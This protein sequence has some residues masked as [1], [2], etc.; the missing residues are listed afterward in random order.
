MGLFKK[1]P[2]VHSITSL[3]SKSSNGTPTAKRAKNLTGN[4]A[5]KMAGKAQEAQGAVDYRKSTESFNSRYAS[6]GLHET[7]LSDRQFLKVQKRFNK[8][9]DKFDRKKS[10]SK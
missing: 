5:S 2:Q 8:A 1:K 7:T 10:R 3:G 9:Q 4:A 6:A